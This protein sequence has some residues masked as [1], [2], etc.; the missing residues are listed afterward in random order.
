[1]EE[2]RE[3]ERE[4]CSEVEL[5]SRLGEEG[6]RAIIERDH[7]FIE[8]TEVAGQRGQVAVRGVINMPRQVCLLDR[9]RERRAHCLD[10]YF[11]EH[12]LLLHMV[13][14]HVYTY[15]SNQLLQVFLE[16]FRW[17]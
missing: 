12:T 3:R 14:A 11:H 7:L 6:E 2:G 9:Q 5:H 17:Q 8:V 13:H 1:M 16:H 15:S 4:P 10:F